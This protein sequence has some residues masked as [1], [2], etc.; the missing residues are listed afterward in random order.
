MLPR[1]YAEAGLR[2]SLFNIL[3]RVAL[4]VGAVL[5]TLMLA[6]IVL[7]NTLIPVVAGY[8]MEQGSVVA[9]DEIG[10][11]LAP[12]LR[13]SMTNG[14][15]HVPV[16]TDRLGLRDEF[17]PNL[18]TPGFVAIGDSQTFGHGIRAEDTW[19]EQLQRTLGA[20][21][22]N[23]GV[24]GYGINQYE[25]VLRRLREAGVPIRVVLYAMSWN[26]LYSALYPRDIRIVVDG[27]L[28]CN[29][30]YNQ[31]RG[32]APLRQRI[33]A[34]NAVVW[35]KTRTAIGAM[36]RAG[37]NS[38][39]GLLGTSAS[40]GGEES[41]LDTHARYTKRRLRSLENFLDGIGARLVIVHL[42]NANLATLEGLPSP[43]SPLAFLRSRGPG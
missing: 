37:G 1:K 3:G 14:H 33:L 30:A 9:D 11:R 34:S 16:E 32:R 2:G 31:E 23:T 36:F 39:L 28:E 24:F 26:D 18:L 19:V 27:Y 10:Y 41:R 25:P 12:N 17:E 7:R 6:E 15:F 35:F 42:G 20:N 38:L 40:G 21:V 4:A 29:P 8:P 22:V 43:L 13:T 5:F